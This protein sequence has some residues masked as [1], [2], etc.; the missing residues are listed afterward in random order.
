MLILLISLSSLFH[1]I[2]TIG[3]ISQSSSEASPYS[4][5][6]IENI[7]GDRDNCCVSDLSS[8]LPHEELV[9]SIGNNQESFLSIYGNQEILSYARGASPYECDAM[10]V[11]MGERA[12]I[13]ETRKVPNVM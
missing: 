2:I 6:L 11:Q 3:P 5:E 4:I 13:K 1:K 9:P 10:S 8:A 12:F 7:R